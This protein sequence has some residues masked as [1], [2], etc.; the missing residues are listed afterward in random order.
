MRKLPLLLA[1]AMEAKRVPE[2]VPITFGK[3]KKAFDFNGHHVPEGWL[4]FLAVTE[5]N[6]DA[7][8][9]VKPLEF[10]PERFGEARGEDRRPFAYV[11]Q[12]AGAPEGHKCLGADFSTAFLETFTLQLVRDCEYT[13]PEQ[14]WKMRRDLVPPEYLSGLQGVVKR[15][16]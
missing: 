11:P 3:A 2:I 6:H 12:G 1:C 14:G 10:D 15:R 7:G 9:F 4:L 5:N 16:A 13:L 8:A